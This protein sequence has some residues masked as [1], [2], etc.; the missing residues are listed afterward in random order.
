MRNPFEAFSAHFPKYFRDAFFPLLNP[1]R[2]PCISGLGDV[3]D[4]ILN[5]PHNTK[6]QY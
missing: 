1:S 5:I 4:V 3:G 2:G 6:H